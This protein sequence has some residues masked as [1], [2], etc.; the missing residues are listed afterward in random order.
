[1]KFAWTAL[2]LLTLS[3]G[4]APA[5][6][7]EIQPGFD[8][9]EFNLP[10]PVE[11][12]VAR[13]DRSDATARTV[14][15]MIAQGQFY[16]VGLPDG[17]R[18]TISAMAARY[19]ETIGF[20]YQVWGHRNDVVA[21]INGDYWEREYYPGGP[22]TGRPAGGQ[23]QGGWFCRWHSF[24]GG[25]SGYY[26]TIWGV[27]H[28]GGDV[29]SGDH[30]DCRQRVIFDDTSTANLTG[31]NVERGTDDL[32]VYTPQWANSTHTDS[33]GVEVLV[34]VSR[35]AL[36]LPHG[37]TANSCN[38]TIIE[39]RDGAG[40]TLIPFDHVVISATGSLAD[41]LR[42][43]CT[44]GDSLDLQLLIRDYGLLGRT[45][46]HPAQ[47]WTKAY[48]S[49]GVDREIVI[50]STVTNLPSPDTI[51]RARSAV[52]F[53]DTHVF[54]VV[55]E[56]ITNDGTSGMTF[57]ELAN[58]M[59]TELGATEG[60]S[61]DGGGSSALWIQGLGIVNSPSDGNER[62]TCNGLMMIDILPREQSIELVDGITVEVQGD[63]PLRLGPGTN[64]AAIANVAEGEYG[65][66]QPHTLNGVLA[67]GSNWWKCDVEGTEGWLPESAL[68]GVTATQSWQIYR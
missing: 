59:I 66:V 34:D 38:G 1:V 41:T 33:T 63:L 40:D 46:P 37:T 21:A 12:F 30:S 60:A 10:G 61:L 68:V 48:G 6:W 32:I 17:G 3:V 2:L 4:S 44:V 11:V 54:F 39:V 23:V 53:N 35:P 57:A 50:A 52:A 67:T 14:D 51:Q 29:S 27:P 22:Y 43:K 55:V 16:K 9:R 28:I 25:G 49:I 36:P 20:H 19:D 65:I 18:E 24:F 62:A 5:Q 26:H 7:T 45:P 15:S 47:D 56:E 42:T 8:Y 13:M 64:Y 58:F 31:L